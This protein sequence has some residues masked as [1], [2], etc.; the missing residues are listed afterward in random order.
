MTLVEQVYA[1]VID[2]PSNEK[3]GLTSQVCRAAVSIPSN[4]AEGCSR[5]SEREFMRFVEIALGST[6]E[7]ETQL[8]LAHRIGYLSD[9][10]KASIATRLELIQMKLGA[11]RNKLK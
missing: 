8:D 7:L 5:S 9:S 10:N 2:F 1:A 4:I 3:F 11:L 6:Y